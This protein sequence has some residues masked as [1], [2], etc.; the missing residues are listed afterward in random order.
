MKR[1][2][3]AIRIIPS[4]TMI[5][6]VESLSSKAI[7]EIKWTNPDTWH[8]T[9]V[10]TGSL[11]NTLIRK[12]NYGL[13]TI[14]ERTSTFGLKIL[15]FGTFGS[16]LRPKVLWIG[17][18]LDAQLAELQRLVADKIFDLE[19]QTDAKPFHP[20]ITLGRIRN[21]EKPDELMEVI[22]QKGEFLWGEFSVESIVFYESKLS[23]QGPDYH[24]MN[25]FKLRGI[26]NI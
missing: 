11:P 22:V 21:L 3:I 13:K 19:I 2:F 5:E 25:E 7:G 18:L 6:F 10:F 15:G 16:Q 24:V 26:K 23:L 20:H 12:V 14:A 8:I 9:L 1:T 17:V 4:T